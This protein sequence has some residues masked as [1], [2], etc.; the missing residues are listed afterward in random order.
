MRI[1]GG[2]YRGRR[3][4]APRGHAIRPTSDRLREALFNIIGSAVPGAR[5]LDL[6]AGSGALGLEAL[7]RGAR[8][9]V[10][11]E[12]RRHVLEVLELNIAA[13]GAGD[14]CVVRRVDAARIMPWVRD[15]HFD[16]VLADPPYDAPYAHELVSAFIL[17]PFTPLL[18]VEHRSRDAMPGGTTRAYGDAA[19]TCCEAP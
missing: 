15:E 8:E 19:I 18:C 4:R 12:R 1:V 16:I 14:R 10:F 9:V 3:L 6:Y 17:E 2:A 7:S 13:L 5:V 11:V